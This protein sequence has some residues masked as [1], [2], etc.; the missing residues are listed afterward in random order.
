V[1]L[2]LDLRVWSWVVSAGLLAHIAFSGV[3]PYLYAL[4]LALL[5]IPLW[6]RRRIVIYDGA[7]GLCHRMRRHWQRF[8]FLRAFEW[9][10]S[11]SGAGNQWNIPREALEEK[12]YLVS[13]GA[14][15]SGFRAC[16]HMMLSH[17]FTY[18]ALAA[19][20]GIPPGI[21][22]T[23]LLALALAFFFPLLEPVGEAVYAWVARNRYRLSSGGSCATDA[24]Q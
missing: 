11:Q 2:L 17:P 13:G 22:R 24:K 5:L 21:L 7:C 20:L 1:K 23:L 16:K 4:E 18:F 14:V 6:P 9:E 3:P 8:D 10:T 12:L 15:S 19:L